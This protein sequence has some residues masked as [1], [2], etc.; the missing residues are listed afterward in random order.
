M[1]ALVS[2]CI[3]AYRAE[4]FIG[5]AIRSVLNQTLTDFELI[6]VD[7][8]SPDGT[9]DVIESFHDH[10]IV[11]S[12]NPR[13]V[14]AA[15]NWNDVVSRAAG[16]YVKLLCSD[17]WLRPDCLARQ[18]AVLAQDDPHEEISLVSARRDIVDEVDRVLLAGRGL[19]TMRG[20]VPGAVAVK[21]VVR[22]GTNLIGE[23][24]TA[25]FRRSLFDRVGGFDPRAA[26]MIDLDFWLRLLD[27]GDFHGIEDTLA[28]FRVQRGSWSATIAHHQAAQARAFF[29]RLGPRGEACR[30]RPALAQL[31]VA[32]IRLGCLRATGL[33]YARNAFFG[34]QAARARRSSRPVGAPTSLV[35]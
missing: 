13:N 19:A 18:V 35:R 20:R 8:A 29:R 9:W 14:G 17:D 6:I 4:R 30:T 25:M 21:T 5:Q 28:V 10:R 32:D 26:Y 22:G 16:R 7:D 23:P 2:V 27:H 11:A 24:S 31:T 33:G 3:P 1:T 12:R 34:L 15:A